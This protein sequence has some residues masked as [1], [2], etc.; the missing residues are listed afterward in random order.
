M[1]AGCSN[2]H[3][4]PVEH[5]PG[6][7]MEKTLQ[8]LGKIDIIPPPGPSRFVSPQTVMYHLDGEPP[9][10]PLASWQNRSITGC[11]SQECSAGCHSPS[12]RGVHAVQ[13]AC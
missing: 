7:V 2:M 9:S 8:R 6:G 5:S 3:V 1:Q 4:H 13:R 12:T 11:A 10:G